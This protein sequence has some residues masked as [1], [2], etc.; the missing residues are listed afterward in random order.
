MSNS[1]TGDP[2]L[3]RYLADQYRLYHDQG[4][5]KSEA[6]A[7]A[8]QDMLSAKEQGFIPGPEAPEDQQPDALDAVYSDE[9]SL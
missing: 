2:N 9:G 6:H 8:F 1:F 7:A 3:Q 5:T 4:M